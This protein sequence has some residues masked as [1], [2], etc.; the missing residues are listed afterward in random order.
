MSYFFKGE[1]SSSAPPT[2]AALCLQAH[3]L[4]PWALSTPP[5]PCSLF[6][7]P[8]KG[9][10]LSPRPSSPPPG[11]IK[12]VVTTTCRRSKFKT[13]ELNKL[14]WVHEF[15]PGRVK[16]LR[17]NRLTVLSQQNWPYTC[18]QGVPSTLEHPSWSPETQCGR[19]DLH[20]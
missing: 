12:V 8:P 5:D 13:E 15:V 11:Y 16:I 10:R 9:T 1:N 20:G 2:V 18:S 6:S 17:G 7:S 4:P 19:P 3:T 14:P